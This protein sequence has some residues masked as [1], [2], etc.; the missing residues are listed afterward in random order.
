MGQEEEHTNERK[1]QVAETVTR[2]V[3]SRNGAGRIKF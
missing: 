1:Q 2:N 3:W